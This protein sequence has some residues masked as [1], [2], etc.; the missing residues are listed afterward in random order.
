MTT[1]GDIIFFHCILFF[2]LDRIFCST[3]LM[4]VTWLLEK[5]SIKDQRACVLDCIK[6]LDIKP[7]NIVAFLFDLLLSGVI[8]CVDP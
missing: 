5:C 4:S 3:I 2:S 7:D 1:F 8:S 6:K